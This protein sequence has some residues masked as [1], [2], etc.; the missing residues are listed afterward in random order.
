M[1]RRAFAILLLCSLGACTNA[2]TDRG[3]RPIVVA[4]EQNLPTELTAESI[5]EPVFDETFSNTP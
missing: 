2:R 3:Y 4:P 5:D 1:K